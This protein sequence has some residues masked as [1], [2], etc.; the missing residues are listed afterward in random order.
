MSHPT[1]KLAILY[2]RNSLNC[3]E[4][5]FNH[6][7]FASYMD[8]IPFRTFTTVE[9]VVREYSE[10]MS[11]DVAWDIQVISLYLFQCRMY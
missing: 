6:P 2:Y 8:C 5:L 9:Q 3:I 1:N 4:A 10:W 11:G 7:Y